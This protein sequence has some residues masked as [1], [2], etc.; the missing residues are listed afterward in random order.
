LVIGSSSDGASRNLTVPD[1][2]IGQ[3]NAHT[4]D[5]AEGSC[6]MTEP[7]VMRMQAHAAPPWAP[8]RMTD[9]PAPRAEEVERARALLRTLQ[10]TTREEPTT[11][12]DL[13]AAETLLA[14]LQR[15]HTP[16]AE[17]S[18][19]VA[20]VVLAMAGRMPPVGFSLLDV[21]LAALLHDIGKLALPDILLN[22][23]ATLT[24][25]ERMLVRTHPVA[26]ALLLEEHGLP[27]AARRAALCHHE[28]WNGRGYPAQ[29]QGRA[30]PRV[31]RAVAAA[32]MLVAMTE[33]GRHYR[34][35]SSVAQAMT[36]LGEQ[37]GSQLDP[38]AVHWLGHVTAAADLER[39]IADPAFC[40][41]AV[42]KFLGRLVLAPPHT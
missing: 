15:H 9:A 40:R 22:S 28:W 30:I 17:H 25:A 29:V 38:A 18:W 21:I 14:Q 42:R 32:D 31:A 10:A 33:P 12:R 24:V 11:L 37:S 34:A 20:G 19:R 35:A 16:S 26:G 6:D 41:D 5:R 1:D 27:L 8:L 2:Q 7:H 23:A 39:L 4:R 13:E 36:E 3:G